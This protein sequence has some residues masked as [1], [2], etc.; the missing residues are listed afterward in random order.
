MPRDVLIHQIGCVQNGGVSDRHHTIVR[1]LQGLL[2]QCN[3]SADLEVPLNPEGTLRM[4]IVAEDKDNRLYIDVTVA[5]SASKTHEGKPF[6]KLVKEKTA[7]KEKSYGAIA[8][9]QGYTLHTFFVDTFGKMDAKSLSLVRMLHK[10][11]AGDPTISRVKPLTLAQTL[12]PLS[13]AIAYGNAQCIRKGRLLGA[14]GVDFRNALW[15]KNGKKTAEHEPG[16]I[17]VPAAD[18]EDVDD[19]DGDDDDTVSEE[20]THKKPHSFNNSEGTTGNA[21]GEKHGINPEELD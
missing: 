15:R 7:E 10:K 17:P 18:E 12:A 19:D 2:R 5:S 13:E 21:D 9:A 8:A 6:E 14:L 16:S 11:I 4:D 1:Y 3:F 20:K